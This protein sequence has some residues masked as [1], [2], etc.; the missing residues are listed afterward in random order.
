MTRILADLRHWMRDRR[1]TPWTRFSAPTGRENGPKDQPSTERVPEASF[2]RRFGDT[3]SEEPKDQRKTAAEDVVR[4]VLP[5][6][7]MNK[8]SAP[9]PKA[10][11]TKIPSASGEI[12]LLVGR[13]ST[14]T[15]NRTSQRRAVHRFLAE[16]EGLCGLGCSHR[17]LYRWFS[18]HLDLLASCRLGEDALCWL[19]RTRAWVSETCDG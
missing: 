15:E 9:V 8:P 17:C 13:P 12:I 14:S 16:G 1:S 5:Q 4:P 7:P 3:W 10:T 6:A 11:G 2:P 18:G 19:P